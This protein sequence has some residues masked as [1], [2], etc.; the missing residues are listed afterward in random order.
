MKKRIFIGLAGLVGVVAGL[1]HRRI[2]AGLN[3]PRVRAGVG[4]VGTRVGSIVRRKTQVQ[5]LVCDTKHG[6]FTLNTP[7]GVEDVFLLELPADAL[8]HW[9]EIA[10]T[11]KSTTSGQYIMDRLPV[12]DMPNTVFV[13]QPNSDARK[14]TKESSDITPLSSEEVADILVVAI[15][16]VAEAE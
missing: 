15:N 1:N 5:S 3:H 10:K 2:R 11:F 16:R 6:E 4:Q 12:N 7:K 8:S 9:N 14:D 13:I